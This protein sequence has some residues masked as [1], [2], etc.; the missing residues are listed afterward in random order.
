MF[1]LGFI[2]TDIMTREKFSNSYG[3]IVY[4]VL[5]RIQAYSDSPAGRNN[6]VAAIGNGT[7]PNHRN[8][9]EVDKQLKQHQKQDHEIFLKL[10]SL[11]KECW[12]QEPTKRPKATEI[13]ETTTQQM[14]ELPAMEGLDMEDLTHELTVIDGS[15]MEV[16]TMDD[17]DGKT[18]TSRVDELPVMDGSGSTCMIMGGYKQR[19]LLKL[20]TSTRKVSNQ[21]SQPCMKGLVQPV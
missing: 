12:Q 10:Q 7:R 20:M 17:S 2:L 4:E 9:D 3:I 19:K 8:L 13:L 11:M 6:I 16:S 21:E 5:T 1:S 14:D 18:I 15:D